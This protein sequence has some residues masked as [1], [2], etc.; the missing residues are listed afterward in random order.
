[1]ED[2][3]FVE[4][5]KK[6]GEAEEILKYGDRKTCTEYALA[7]VDLAKEYQSILSARN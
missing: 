4:E 6:G 5:A 2:P 1:M 3:A 7:M